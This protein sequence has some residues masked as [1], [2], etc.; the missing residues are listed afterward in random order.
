VSYGED[1]KHSQREEL[2]LIRKNGVG[3]IIPPGVREG[4]TFA[5][6]KN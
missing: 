1:A 5:K 3:I 6:Q 2:S 4:N